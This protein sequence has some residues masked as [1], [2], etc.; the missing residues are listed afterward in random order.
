MAEPFWEDQL[1]YLS[2]RMARATLARPVTIFE[3][4]IC[5]MYYICVCM[6]IVVNWLVCIIV[7][8][9]RNPVIAPFSLSV[10]LGLS[11]YIDTLQY[12][13][14]DILARLCSYYI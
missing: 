5:V 7:S 11:V 14:Q 10:R 13:C 3:C 2:F 8:C 1:H 6:P 4:H 9:M 12:M